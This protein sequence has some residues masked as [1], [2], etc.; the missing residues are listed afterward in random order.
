MKYNDLIKRLTKLDKKYSVKIIG[1]TRFNR[2]IFAVEKRINNSFSTAI[3]LAGIH[4][5]EFISSEVL[6]KMIEENLFDKIKDFNLSFICMANPDGIDLER[7]EIKSFSKF[8]QRKLLKINNGSKDFLLW[9]ANARGVDLNNNFDAK[10]YDVIHKNKPSC[11]GFPGKKP[12]SER[13]TKAIA[14]YTKSIEPFITISYHTKG[15]EIYYNF[16]QRGERLIRDEIIAKRFEKS[17]GYKI[18]NVESSS[19][20][21]YKDWCVEKLKIPALTIELGN[22][23]LMHPITTENLNEI[24]ERN[25]SIASDLEFA[26]NVYKNF[27]ERIENEL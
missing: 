7:G 16:F 2:K 6:M 3:F 5:R 8:Q 19:A 11:Q 10:F 26:Y 4:A 15:E 17:T 24:F 14:R 20:G 22:D 13:E 18:V 25:K 12:M 1:K 27:K 9:K 23:D 21:G